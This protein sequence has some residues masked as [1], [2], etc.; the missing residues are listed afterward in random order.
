[1]EF[2]LIN[3]SK[4]FIFLINILISVNDRIFNCCLIIS[5]SFQKI[6]GLKDEIANSEFFL[7]LI[8]SLSFFNLFS[9]YKKDL[10]IKILSSTE[11]IFS[12]KIWIVFFVFFARH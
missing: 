11:D 4:L 3:S 1:M 12:F 10:I 9:L 6:G 8:S 7:I 5:F 2:F